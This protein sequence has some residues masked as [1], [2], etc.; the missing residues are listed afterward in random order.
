MEIII[1][2]PHYLNFRA[3]KANKKLKEM[4]PCTHR[5]GRLSSRL[6]L[7]NLGLS[8]LSLL[9]LGLHWLLLCC[10]CW[11]RLGLPCCGGLRLLLLLLLLGAWLL[12]LLPLLLHA[13][14]LG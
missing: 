2:L 8:R 4:L 13:L 1:E 6:W 5:C 10:P 14:L 11:L 12:A 7:S 9:L 3:N